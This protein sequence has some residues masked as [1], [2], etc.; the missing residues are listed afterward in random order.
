[1]IVAIQHCS[2]EVLLGLRD[3]QDDLGQRVI[4]R[5]HAARCLLRYTRHCD[6]DD[7]NQDQKELQ[8]RIHSITSGD[9]RFVLVDFRWSIS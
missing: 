7:D 8:I 1:M 6:Q 4:S 9:D 5:D 2:D 3:I